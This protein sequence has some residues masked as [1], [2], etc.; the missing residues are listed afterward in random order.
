METFWWEGFAR[1]SLVDIF[2]GNIL[3]G[4]HLWEIFSGKVSEGNLWEIFGENIW[5]E[6][7]DGKFLMGNFVWE[8]WGVK[9]LVGKIWC[10]IFGGN[11]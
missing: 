6:I 2:Y 11:Y 7:F 5:W 9:F 8:I 3:M 1:K 4:N 10:K